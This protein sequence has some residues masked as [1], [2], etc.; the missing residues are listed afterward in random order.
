MVKMGQDKGR[1]SIFWMALK[2]VFLM[3][4]TLIAAILAHALI[5]IAIN[6]YYGVTMGHSQ[7]A[8][9]AINATINNT[10]A[11][12]GILVLQNV[13]FVL[14]ALL[15][16]KIDK[17]KFTL[18]RLG[19]TWRKD[20]P[21]LFLAGMSLDLI[22]IVL[23]MALL[24]VTGVVVYKGFGPSIFG[25][26]SVALSF[27]LM[28]FATLSIG[29]GEEVLFRGYLQRMLTNRYGIMVALP[30]ASLIFVLVHVL[31][32]LMNN[33]LPLFYFLSILPIALLLGYLFY[34]TGSLWICIGFHF[35]EDFL[36]LNVLFAGNDVSGTYP[37]FLFS[38][39]KII[40]ESATWLGSWGDLMGFVIASAVLL[41]VY[42]YNHRK[43]DK[44]DH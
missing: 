3:I 39:P 2:L 36:V 27:V 43:P 21:K 44:K 16:L 41:A 22:T 34:K 19:L 5:I 7:Q 23:L 12:A 29:I 9:D 17:E 28:L 42:A 40:S 25:A 32:Q 37:L 31:P 35:F 4:A 10:W 1:N 14:V 8:T 13:A 6:V 38:E 20:T 33:K 24:A 26:S 30:L 18:D 15:F 11:Q